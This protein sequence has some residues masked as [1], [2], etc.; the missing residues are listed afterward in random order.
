MTGFDKKLLEVLKEHTIKNAIEVLR[1][2]DYWQEHEGFT[3]EEFEEAIIRC[4]E[5]N[6][7]AQDWNWLVEETEM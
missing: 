5:G 1:D 3:R 7:T 2:G 6:G 4:Q